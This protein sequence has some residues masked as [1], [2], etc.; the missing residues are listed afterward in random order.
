MSQNSF[1][2]NCD[3]AC[4]PPQ[5]VMMP[6][7]MEMD[8][9]KLPASCA[10]DGMQLP[11]DLYVSKTGDDTNDGFT[12]ETAFA[13]IQAAVSSTKRFVKTGA[14]LTIHVAS[15]TYNET[16]EIEF[17]T[18]VYSPLKIQGDATNYP[19]VIGRYINATNLGIL[20]CQHIHFH[21]KG[22]HGFAANYGVNFYVS[23]CRVTGENTSYAFGTSPNSYMVVGDNVTVNGSFLRIFSCALNSTMR[24]SGENVTLNG[25]VSTATA[26]AFIGGVIQ[27]T[28]A[29][30]GTVTGKR[31]LSQQMGIIIGST[32]LPGT[33]NGTTETG[34]M[35]F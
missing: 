28:K 15:G 18:G 8:V 9:S 20:S 14:V 34:G 35:A 16:V 4:K 2:S 1:E 5:Y 10:C 26:N 6:F 3:C 27:V 21:S 30:G 32:Y 23:D 11:R 29:I 24:I 19:T 22:A 25:T 7:R 13:T 31:Y 33:V 17:E 12:P